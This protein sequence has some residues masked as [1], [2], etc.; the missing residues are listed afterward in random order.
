[1]N[2]DKRRSRSP[3]PESQ[4][5]TTPAPPWPSAPPPPPPPPSSPSASVPSL[6]V[7]P[8]LGDFLFQTLP[9]PLKLPCLDV[10]PLA[11]HDPRHRLAFLRAQQPIR[12][13]LRR[14][15]SLLFQTLRR[16]HARHPKLRV[17]GLRHQAIN[18][19]CTTAWP[20][21]SPLTPAP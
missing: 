7:P 18:A 10:A 11:L 21:R 17:R 8:E 6:P 19:P 14:R 13:R 20:S 9:P 5:N 3:A 12:H 1:M 15:R 2:A 4:S 16:L